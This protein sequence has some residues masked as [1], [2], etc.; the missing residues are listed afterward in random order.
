MR[1]ALRALA[2]FGG[3]LILLA[4][5]AFGAAQSP[6]AK[7]LLAR[8]LSKRLSGPDRTVAIGTLSGWIPFEL[9][10][11]EL[12]IL[13]EHGPW[14]TVLDVFLQWRPTALLRGR[15][16]GELLTA[17]QVHLARLPSGARTHEASASDSPEGPL[18]NLPMPIVVDRFLLHQV[19]ADAP[20][21]GVPLT[22]AFEGS[23]TFRE[24]DRAQD[25]VIKMVARHA[26]RETL[27]TVQATLASE[28]PRLQ[29]RVTLSEEENG[30]LASRLG[31]KNVGSLQGKIHAR[32]ETFQDPSG[33]L[34]MDEVEF[35]ARDVILTAR[36]GYHLKSRSL[37][38][39]SYRVSAADLGGLDALTGV[40]LHGKATVEGT[41]EGSAARLQGILNLTA[42][43]VETPSWKLSHTASQLKW[44]LKPNPSSPY[45]E[46]SVDLRG[47]TSLFPLSGVS[48]PAL[49]DLALELSAALSPGGALDIETLRVSSSR[50][51]D[52][53]LNGRL[54][55]R[56]RTA[57]GRIGLTFSDLS[58][59]SVLTPRP[60]KGD[61]RGE[62]AFSGSWDNMTVQTSIQG[63]AFAF[64]QAQ[65]TDWFLDLQ[66]SGLPQNPTGRITSRAAY[67]G[68]PWHLG[69]DFAKDGSWVHVSNLSFRCQDASLEGAL[70]VHLETALAA[71]SLRVAVP[72]L[73]VLAPVLHK[74]LR[75]SLE[76][77][78]DL[79]DED[80]QQQLLGNLTVRSAAFDGI[81]VD[82]L[83]LSAQFHA[84]SPSPRGM[85][86]LTVHNLQ[87]PPW[88]VTTGEA[89]VEGGRD[90]LT[91]STRVEGMLKHPFSLNTAGTARLDTD[92]KELT[93]TSFDGTTGPVV[94]AL[95]GPAH[96]AIH[97]RGLETSPI[98]VRVGDGR[99]DGRI[100]WVG[101]NP[102]ASLDIQHI[103]L[104]LVRHFGGPPL[105]GRLNAKGMLRR[106]RGSPQA[107]LSLN[108]GALRSPAWP[109][110]ETLSLDGTVRADGNTLRV[111][112]ELD[113]LGPEPTRANLSVPIRFRTDPLELAVLQE[114]PM[115]GGASL[116]LSLE[117]VG[118]LLDL[119]NHK[120]QGLLTGRLTFAGTVH[121]PA[122]NGDVR[123]DKGRYQHEDLGILLQDISAVVDGNGDILNLRQ[124][125]AS[126]GKKGTIQGV[127]EIRLDPE[128]RFPYEATL[129]VEDLSPLHRDDI[130]GNINGTLSLRGRAEETFVKG[131]LRVRPLRLRLP[132]RLPPNVVPL[133]VEEIGEGAPPPAR[134]SP[135]A[136]PPIP[137][138]V[139]LD[140]S[141]DFPGMTT[142]SGWGLESEWKGA[143]TI[144]GEAPKPAVTGG[145]HILRGHLLFL[146]KRFR[147]AQGEVTFY[148]DVPPDPFVNVLGETVLRDMTAEVRLSGRASKLQLSIGSRPERPQ[149][150]VLAQILFGRSATTLSPFQALRLASILQALSSGS[151]GGS[152]FDV[153]GKT[154][155]LL[156]LEQLELL[157]GGIGEGLQVG[158]GK[159]LGEN[160]RVDVN[161]RLEQGDVSLRIEVEV[162]P[163]ITLETQAG[164]QSRTGAGVF[165]KY[166]Y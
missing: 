29:A 68:G 141:V 140:I 118:T 84:L 158:L 135:R 129:T 128:A 66:T 107:E 119:D 14:L 32:L 127:G 161:Q 61:L 13:D 89:A 54:H 94:V 24:K 155:D 125:K 122:V 100:Q 91:F 16:H 165:W 96:V 48:S 56:Q 138:R 28:E 62:A 148:G 21:A 153:L 40:P 12:Q 53:A 109:P 157:G 104:D 99:L 80:A 39:T 49:E 85:V 11:S 87:K 15:I 106:V 117:R 27:C 2:A 3:G 133:D 59:L 79:G 146:T 64:G 81:G 136:P 111:G 50:L 36:G 4:A 71:G 108:V 8:E 115:T 51:G 55:L 42:D 110:Q 52:A 92:T 112:V 43:D 149:D 124:F 147:L 72:R 45:P 145:L 97:A 164:T 163:N 156:G 83:H 22:A 18:P 70:R 34:W 101:E 95:E 76:G 77:T 123:L 17:R 139:L 63:S 74:D 126:D 60:M 10:V 25:T 69:L 105:E 159:Y 41:V 142:L 120:M 82:R 130:S 33:T 35:K 47:T 78:L 116:A 132:E 65:W 20:V 131:S 5:A 26:H 121:R 37:K 88:T 102:F 23:I 19:V 31:L 90:R 58:L 44:V 75:G 144:S 86:T 6:A 137:H 9:G 93:V 143:L 30:W 103:P 67:G 114:K 73:E 1:R 152:S 98:R 151:G 150:E 160:V 57:E 46:V 113:G 7:R 154:R 38:P 162:T 166:D 134:K